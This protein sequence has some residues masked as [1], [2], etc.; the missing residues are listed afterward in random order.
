MS[1]NPNNTGKKL[2]TF[3]KS[4]LVF[5][6]QFDDSKGA[7]LSYY[8]EIEGVIYPLPKEDFIEIVT[9]MKNIYKRWTNLE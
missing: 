1:G 5:G 4:G 3:E 7:E 2:Y 9:K 8:I 6:A